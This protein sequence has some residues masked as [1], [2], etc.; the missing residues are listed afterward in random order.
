MEQDRWRQVEEVVQAALDCEPEQRSA[1]LDAAC[2]GDEALRREV[3]SLLAAS[4]DS[5]FTEAPAFQD[6]IRLLGNKKPLAGRHIGPYRVTR[7]LGQGGMG[8]VYLA[9]RADEAFEKQ[10]A[11]KVIQRGLGT[12]SMI[13]RFRAERQ[14]LASLDHPNI[15]RLLDG[16]I[17][18]D[19]LQYLVMEYIEGEAIDQYCQ[20]RNLGIAE[21]LTL[22]LQ[23]CAAVHYAHQNLIIHR[24]IKPSNILVTAEGVP[25]LL[26]F[27]IAK[28]LNPTAQTNGATL[29]G[30]R[31]MTLDYA[32]PEQVSG[33]IITTA[34][35]VY[36]LGVVLYELLTSA[37]P[38]RLDGKTPAQVEHA[39]CAEESAHPSE[40]GGRGL[41]GDLD[42]IVLMAM[43]KEPQ[44][45][46]AS[47]EQ[48]SDD[49]K[50]HLANLPVIARADTRRYRTAKFLRRHKA[51]VAAAAVLV[52][53][54][55]AGIVATAW[56]ARVARLEASKAQRINTF[57]QDIL[58]FANT[59]WE[60]S[61]LLKNPDAKISEAVELAASRAQAELADQPEV[62]AEMRRT[63][64]TVYIGQGRWREAEQI[65][66]AAYE[67]QVRLYGPDHHEVAETGQALGWALNQEGDFA[68]SERIL[69]AAANT[70]RKEVQRR[71]D[72]F[73]LVSTLGTLGALFELK[74]DVRA[75]ESYYREA[76]QYSSNVT[77]KERA[78][79][80]ILDTNLGNLSFRR[81]D[82]DAA[83]RLQRAAVEE[84]RKL[85][86]GNYAELGVSLAYLGTVLMRK[87]RFAEAEPLMREGLEIERKLLGNMHNY[88]AID[89][90]ALGDLL[91]YKGD[92]R[93][94]EDAAK[95]AL[96]IYEKTLPKGNG[97][98]AAPL[99]QL[100]L[101]LN[102]TGRSLEGESDVREALAILH[103]LLPAG[104]Q[105]IAATEGA[106]GEC[107]T[108]QQRF[109]EAEPL[110][111]RSYAARKS[112]LGEQDPR[113]MEARQRLTILYGAW[114]KSEEAARYSRH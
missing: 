89:L 50:R 42:N 70:F 93:A 91:Y 14:I 92:Y 55:T 56:Q 90:I 12:E 21:R 112:N 27:G 62:L 88:T 17:T 31:L 99:V 32:S 40:V 77:G 65:L 1:L 35:D 96:H 43:R 111:L 102:K 97:S 8:E 49:I 51:G 80:A 10:V 34:S 60:S 15:T 53:T 105:S 28:L 73:G 6:A 72:L 4:R 26:D 64:G 104:H 20:K 25:R 106:L 67:A 84:Y 98:F 110:L 63:I 100:G 9:A 86:A 94:A 69:R 36:S 103:L 48:L 38:H 109:A 75:A 33:Q 2:T 79:V 87:S 30:A 54:L 74:G 82:L 47:A 22:F 114:G 68:E 45:R 41:R 85:P 81:G 108:T 16:G 83:E 71:P 37:K 101:I 19:G 5:D 52:S 23:V 3:E 7:E 113:T 66:R 59:G 29:T 107:L 76:L 44:R 18:E 13:Q 24:D 57:L 39:I 11:I 78:M 61:N 46:Y 58:G 95:E